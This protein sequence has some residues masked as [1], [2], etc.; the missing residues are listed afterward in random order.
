VDYYKQLFGHNVQCSMRLG[1]DFW[2]TELNLEGTNKE[3]LTKP[4]SLEE[5]KNVV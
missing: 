3:Q 2:P 5:V 4:F 1:E